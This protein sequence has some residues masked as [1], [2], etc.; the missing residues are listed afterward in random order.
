MMETAMLVKA[1]DQAKR[2]EQNYVIR[3]W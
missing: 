2:Y 3:R 1:D